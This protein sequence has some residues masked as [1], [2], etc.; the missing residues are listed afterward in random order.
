MGTRLFM[1][2]INYLG[3]AEA[4]NGIKHRHVVNADNG[5]NM[6]HFQLG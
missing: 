3:F 2:H 6:L 1:P 5:K 4:V